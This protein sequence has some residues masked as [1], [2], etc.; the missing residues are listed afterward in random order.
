[1]IKLFELAVLSPDKLE[2]SLFT[3]APDLCRCGAWY[4]ALAGHIGDVLRGATQERSRLFAGEDPICAV[5]HCIVAP[6]GLP[7]K[8]SN[9]LVT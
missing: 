6:S 4:R 3:E 5:G 2:R 9:N 8:A 1:M 7:H